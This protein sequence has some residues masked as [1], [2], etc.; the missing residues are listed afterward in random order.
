MLIQFETISSGLK[1]NNYKH[2]GEQAFCL[3]KAQK[4]PWKQ[5]PRDDTVG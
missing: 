3:L 2:G 5:F 4:D 1:P